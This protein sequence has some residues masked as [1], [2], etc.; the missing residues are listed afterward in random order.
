MKS[1]YLTKVAVRLWLS[2]AESDRVWGVVQLK[3][4]VKIHVITETG[5]YL[6]SSSIRLTVYV[7]KQE[8][9]H[10]AHEYDSCWQG[11]IS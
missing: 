11:V 3:S 7:L 9:A 8:R 1:L 2:R 10:K 5:L 4:E 6:A